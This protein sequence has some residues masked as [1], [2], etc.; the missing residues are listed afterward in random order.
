MTL[1][2]PTHVS[3]ASN[4][5]FQELDDES[6]LLNLTDEKYYALNE[7]GT[8]IWQLLNENSDVNSMVEQLLAEYDGVN[9]TTLRADLADLIDKLSDVNLITVES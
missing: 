9:E 2:L 8:R 1:S 5:I 7:V 4:V 3:L 6:V